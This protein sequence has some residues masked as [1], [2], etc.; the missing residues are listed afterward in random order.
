V[1][2]EKPGLEFHEAPS[3]SARLR[4][5]LASASHHET[6]LTTAN[7]PEHLGIYAN[8]SKASPRELTVDLVNYHH[9]L[10][11]D[12]ITAVSRDD[13]T[14]T[15]RI[16]DIKT[17]AGLC[18]ETISYDETAQ[19]NTLRQRL[20]PDQFSTVEGLVTVRIPPFTHYQIIRFSVAKP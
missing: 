18:V 2:K 13:F 11:T 1:I 17:S 10:A 20:S 8:T 14:I 5:V 7:A 6:V 15:L 3:K 12:H 9:D 19:N 4:E 16:P